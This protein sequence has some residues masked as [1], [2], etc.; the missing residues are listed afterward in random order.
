MLP[1][2]AGFVLG[3]AA[4]LTA[5][6]LYAASE[7]HKFKR[8]IVSHETAVVDGIAYRITRI[9]MNEEETNHGKRKSAPD[10]EEV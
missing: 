1:Y 6:V 9:T 7:V 10:G 4:A 8:G 2:I 5:A 3:V